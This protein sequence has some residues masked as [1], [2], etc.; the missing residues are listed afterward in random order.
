MRK[1]TDKFQTNAEI[2]NHIIESERESWK[3]LEVLGRIT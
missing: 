3:P 1:C 2:D